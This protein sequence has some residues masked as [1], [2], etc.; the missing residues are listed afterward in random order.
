MT[1]IPIIIEE[2][3]DETSTLS[4]AETEQAHVKLSEPM[5]EGADPSGHESTKKSMESCLSESENLNVA[6]ESK[7]TSETLLPDFQSNV[8]LESS[9]SNIEGASG[10]DTVEDVAVLAFHQTGAKPKQRHFSGSAVAA[11]TQSVCDSSSPSVAVTT[12]KLLSRGS[13]PPPLLP[14]SIVFPQ[15]RA[16]P[17]G[18]RGRLDKA[19]SVSP[20]SCGVSSAQQASKAVVARQF[21]VP[22]RFDDVFVFPHPRDMQASGSG[23]HSI[24]G[25]SF[26]HSSSPKSVNLKSTSASYIGDSKSS[27]DMLLNPTPP[28]GGRSSRSSPSG[29]S[30]PG[31]PLDSVST[32]SGLSPKG[33]VGVGK[34]PPEVGGRGSN[35]HLLEAS[36]TPS[37][38]GVM[39]ASRESLFD[40][41]SSDRGGLSKTPSPSRSD[42][43]SNSGRKFGIAL[44]STTGGKQKVMDTG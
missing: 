19:R 11:T 34:G 20:S 36:P 44:P 30:S 22:T 13:R 2:H 16:F 43:S 15:G 41:A 31:C 33:V 6:D 27:L 32:S 9:T 4:S 24:M 10:R 26:S 3:C 37:E 35:S 14:P 38:Q 23:P 39:G 7:P 12:P 8:S 5:S 25:A 29:K 28:P 42:V 21:S 40:S 18:A 17:S 1:P